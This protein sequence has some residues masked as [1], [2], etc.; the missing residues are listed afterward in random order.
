MTLTQPLHF[1]FLLP[2]TTTSSE[3]EVVVKAAKELTSLGYVYIAS[4]NEKTMADRDNIRFMPLRQ[5]QLPCFGS[6]TS[7]MIVRD[8]QLALTAQE[9]YPDSHITV[10]DPA[11]ASLA[12]EMSELLA[13]DDTAAPLPLMVPLMSRAKL[14]KAA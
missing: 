5:Q 2:D 6:V 7:V 3:Q 11:Q 4:P 14:S 1:L 12:H 9:M 13:A 8:R 10:F